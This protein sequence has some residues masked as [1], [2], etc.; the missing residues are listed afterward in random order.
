VL[1]KDIALDYARLLS[2]RNI[3]DT[4]REDGI[5]VVGSPISSQKA[6]QALRVNV[7]NPCLKDCMI[8]T[9]R[10]RTEKDAM[11]VNILCATGP[12]CCVDLSI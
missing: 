1:S 10:E 3:A 5:A 4:S 11:F 8:S 9:L 12:S 2:L 6:Y 7:N